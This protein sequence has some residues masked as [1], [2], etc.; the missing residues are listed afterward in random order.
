MASRLPVPVSR[1]LS[2]FAELVRR[3]ATEARRLQRGVELA[4]ALVQACD[5]AGVTVL[6]P[7]FA[8]TVAASDDVVR[9]G[10]VWQ[11]ELSEGPGLES[12]RGR[13]TVVSQDLRTDPRWRAWGP[14]AADG[15]GVRSSMSV[16]LN[17][18]SDLVESLTLYADRVHVWDDERQAL[19]TTL[20]RQLGLAA[21]DAR[22]L[23]DRERA[24]V[25]RTGLGQAQ[26]IVME[27]FGMS[28]AEAYDHLERLSRSNHLDPVHLAEHIVETREVPGPRRS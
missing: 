9:R 17:L 7:A 10:E 4:V 3:P 19:A 20:A 24:L 22:L 26:G 21:A 1:D 13:T 15:L 5:H 8:E 6:T 12:V 2:D 14:R 11:H 27:R 18:D 23:D 25:S 16:P 28:A